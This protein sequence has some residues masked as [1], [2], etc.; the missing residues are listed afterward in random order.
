MLFS[1]GLRRLIRVLGLFVFLTP[2]D[3]GRAATGT[4]NEFVAAATG[5]CLDVSNASLVRDAGIVET[6]CANKLNQQW[7]LVP[8]GSYYHLVDRSSGMCLNIP[9]ASTSPGVQ[10]IQYPCQSASVTNDQWS[11]A[12]LGSRDQIVSRSSGYCVAVNVGS[13]GGAVIQS[14]CQ[15]GALNEQW[16]VTA[17]TPLGA[18]RSAWSGVI[19]LPVN[20]IA[21][22]N[23]PNG[24][25]LMWS[26]NSE[27]SFQSDIGLQASKTDTAIFDPATDTATQTIVTNPGADMFC[28]GTALLPDGRVLINGGSSSP[29][30]SIYDPAT[31]SWSAGENMNIPRGYEGDTP[32]SNG[33]VLTL[34]GSW[35]GGLG[36]KTGEV[37]TAADGWRV[38]SGVPETNVM[39]SEGV[40]RADNHLWLFATS[41]GGVFHAGPSAQM[42][43]IS[44]SGSGSIR[45]AGRRAND[46]YSINGNAVLFDVGMILKVGGAPSYSQPSSGTTYA[47]DS[48][49]LIDISG[50][51]SKPVEVTELPSMKYRRAFSS[52]VVLPNGNVVVVGGQS[53]PQPFTDTTAV[54]VPE[55]WDPVTATFSLLNPMRTPRTYH[56]TAILLADG[57]VFV[58]G[59]GQCGTGCSRNHLNAEILTPPYLLNA[60][61]THADRPVILTAPARAP[62][63]G[64]L[65]VTTRSSVASFVLMR[66]SSITHTVNNDQRRIPLK[67]LSTTSGS[68]QSYTLSIPKDPGVV[69]PG[70]YMLF[71]LSSRGV[72]SVSKS[73]RIP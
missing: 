28:P 9:Y 47:T 31:D 43:W 35:S 32:L 23:L 2:A 56:S 69:L 55:I 22:A 19:P 20:P 26:S 7:S 24:R 65:A 36:G 27:F 42:N 62:L 50:G 3:P 45:S 12:A 49:Y 5:Q 10:L 44:T 18:L 63:G 29:R 66:L 48:A 25:L 14:K 73:V 34:G 64:T 17:A 39:G 54:L 40:Y 60:D 58:G 1:S 38:L 68:S 21:V 53:V 70:Y 4:Y 67:I 8:V 52:S 71:A 61:G 15:S 33:A 6:P 59:G 37:W 30:T 13:S 46:P 51:S 41:G 57:R 16:T 11:L 72:P